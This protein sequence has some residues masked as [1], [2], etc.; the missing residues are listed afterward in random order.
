M[1]LKGTTLVALKFRDG[2]VIAADRQ[3]TEMPKMEEAFEM[4]KIVEIDGFSAVALAGSP[5]LGFE[6]IN[7]FKEVVLAE[8]RARRKTLSFRGKVN[9][10][11]HL[12]RKYMPLIFD[13]PLGFKLMFVGMNPQKGTSHI[14]DYDPVGMSYEIERP[15]RVIGHDAAQQ[16]L[17]E[18]FIEKSPKDIGER[19][20]VSVVA[21]AIFWASKRSLVTGEN[22]DVYI[23]TKEG[24]EKVSQDRIKKLINN[25]KGR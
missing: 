18:Y 2:V 24:L 8:T 23:I 9:L 19:E 1:N 22:Q 25:F 3:V 4:T 15:F 10:L 12:I 16:H 7:A 5:S 20:A 14:F 11:G 21:E 13:S 17:E 6:I